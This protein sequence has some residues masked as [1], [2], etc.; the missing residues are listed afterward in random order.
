MA[1]QETPTAAGARSVRCRARWAKP[2]RPTRRRRRLIASL[3]SDESD[4]Q[5]MRLT[6][7]RAPS[8][9]SRIGWRALLA[10]RERARRRWTEGSRSLPPGGRP[11]RRRAIAADFGAGGTATGAARAPTRSTR[12]KRW[13]GW[14]RRTREAIEAM[15]AESRATARAQRSRIAVGRA[16]RAGAP[17]AG[18]ARGSGAD[19]W[20]TVRRAAKRAN[21]PTA[22]ADGAARP[23]FGTVQLALSE[24]ARAAP[25]RDRRNCRPCDARL[26]ARPRTRSSSRRRDAPA[27]RKPRSLDGAAVVD[28]HRLKNADAE[29]TAMTMALEEQRRKAEE[30]LTLLAAAESAQEDLTTK[31]AAALLAQEET[32]ERLGTLEDDCKTPATPVNSGAGAGRGG[33]RRGAGRW[34]SEV[35]QPSS[36]AE[37]AARLAE[38]AAGRG[39]PRRGAKPAVVAGGGAGAR[40]DPGRGRRGARRRSAHPAGRGRG[41][42]GAKPRRRADAGGATGRGAADADGAA[43]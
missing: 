10:T 8:P 7:R 5:R 42:A 14:P 43:R 27:P 38:V 23:A 39:G 34:T 33:R 35:A 29:L 18:R 36:D 40:A 32:Q 3:R 17:C 21:G 20:P 12:R 30:T 11:V 15:L 19:G 37:E 28:A 1:E 6:R 9:I 26:D 22:E 41:G 13:R 16:G 24:E 4:A 31:L 25:G 2:A